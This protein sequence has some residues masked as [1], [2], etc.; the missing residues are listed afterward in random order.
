MNTSKT[1][2]IGGLLAVGALTTPLAVD[3]Y[4]L[5]TLDEALVIKADRTKILAEQNSNECTLDKTD[6]TFKDCKLVKKYA[7]ISE[8]KVQPLTHK[9]IKETRKTENTVFFE[10]GDISVARVYV[11]KPFIQ[12]SGEWKHVEFATTTIE[13][14]D[15]QTKEKTIL[16]FALQEKVAYADSISPYSGAGDGRVSGQDGSW[17]TV[18]NASSGNT[19]ASH[20]GTDEYPLADWSNPNYRIWR[21]FFPV[22]T[23]ALPDDATITAADFKVT[24]NGDST[25][26]SNVG[27]LI[28][29]S[30]ASNTSL[31]EA[32]YDNLTLNTPDEGAS[33]VTMDGFS[34]GQV[35]TYSLN[36]TGLTWVSKTGYTNLGIREA[37]DVDNSTPTQIGV[38]VKLRTS[39]YT[40]TASDPYLEITYTSGATTYTTGI[41][42]IDFY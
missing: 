2:L 28:Q 32:D 8:N 26:Y 23:S 11:G 35:F 1:I 19:G 13:A 9:G 22:D 38:N 37:R 24:L 33:R 27:V 21:M 41:S 6:L 14:F 30:Q 25:G 10:E 20:T 39:E 40:G 3:E 7:Y 4:K 42:G 31:V 18:R 16:G 17:S 34:A 15:L 36:A 5:A 12:D 29:T